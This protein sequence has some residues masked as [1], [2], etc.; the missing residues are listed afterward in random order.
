MLLILALALR[1]KQ[2]MTKP[3]RALMNFA[4]FA[5]L[6]STRRVERR[7]IKNSLHCSK[8]DLRLST[9]RHRKL[10]TSWMLTRGRRSTVGDAWE[11]STP[12]GR[13]QRTL[14]R[15]LPAAPHRV[16]TTLPVRPKWSARSLKGAT[17]IFRQLSIL[18]TSPKL[19]PFLPQ[20]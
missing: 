12:R 7:G 17:K 8:I 4:M 6:A 16:C 5:T 9:Q 11:R 14:K 13:M 10:T 3:K 19:P 18:A 1:T 15:Q 20:R 2:H